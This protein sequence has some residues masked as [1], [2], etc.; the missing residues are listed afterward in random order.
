MD[1]MLVKAIQ[2]ISAA[3]LLFSFLLKSTTG[4]ST[5]SVPL[6]TGLGANSSRILPPK[7]GPEVVA[8]ILWEAESGNPDALY[9]AALMAAYGDGVGQNIRTAVAYLHQAAEMG[10]LDAQMALGTIL[11]NRYDDIEPNVK[12]GLMWLKASADQGHL[13]S[14]WALGEALVNGLEGNEGIESG[15]K[16]LREAADSGHVRAVHS[17]G[18]LAEYGVGSPVPDYETARRFYER[19]ATL[20]HSESQYNLALM[21]AAGRGC[22][23]DW[24]S[25]V[26]KFHQAARWGHAGAMLQLGKLCLTGQAFPMSYDAALLWF[27][28]AEEKARDIVNQEVGYLIEIEARKAREELSG[29]LHEAHEVNTKLVSLHMDR[30]T[31]SSD[32]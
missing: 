32:L 9:Q 13:D 17:L 16:L 24:S 18:V 26:A 27:E 14:I 30:N 7:A 2:G 6:L 3:Y 23:Q 15:F 10:H 31:H 21:S 29:L 12:E 22:M 20:G 19:D 11:L 28:A 5:A 1:T 8:K 4:L 25:P